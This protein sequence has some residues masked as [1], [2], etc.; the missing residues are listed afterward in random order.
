M[1]GKIPRFGIQKNIPYAIPRP[2]SPQF[3]ERSD[4][5]GYRSRK[6]FATSQ[7]FRRKHAWCEW[8]VQEGRLDTPSAFTDHILPVKE[9]PELFWDNKNWWALCERCHGRKYQM[10]EFA[11]ASD[12]LELLPVWCRE[13]GARPSQFR[14]LVSSRS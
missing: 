14:P 8:C 4:H 12:Q 2:K 10:E 11:R 9:Y 1:N 5:P 3:A 13:P 6:W 7:G